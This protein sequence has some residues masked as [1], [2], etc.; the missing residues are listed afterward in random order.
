MQVEF[1]HL[2]YNEMHT[3]LGHPLGYQF[4][5]RTGLGLTLSTS[6]SKRHEARH[7]DGTIL[8]SRHDTDLYSVRML[9]MEKI[10]ESTFS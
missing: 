7:S 6:D 3:K 5:Q 2:F 10:Q 4:E 9:K 1:T 8:I